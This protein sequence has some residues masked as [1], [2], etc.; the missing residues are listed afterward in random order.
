MAGM[1]PKGWPLK[2]ISSPATITR[3]PLLANLLHT[4]GRSASKNCASSMPITCTS[5][6]SNSIEEALSTGI[7]GMEFALCDTSAFSKYLVSFLGLK[8][9]TVNLAI[10]ARF[11]LLISSSV[12]PENIAPQTTSM[13]PPNSLFCLKIFSIGMGSLG[14]W[15]PIFVILLL[16][17]Y[18]TNLLNK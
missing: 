1:G 4:S 10:L 16:I 7:D 11:N 14:N 5:P 9:P 13:L 12:L 6:A 8:I 17:T 18:P 15:P 2:S 3:T